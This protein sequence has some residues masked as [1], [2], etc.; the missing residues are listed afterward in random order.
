[1]SFAE[2]HAAHPWD[3]VLGSVVAKTEADVLRALARA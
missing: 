2:V 3:E 1:M